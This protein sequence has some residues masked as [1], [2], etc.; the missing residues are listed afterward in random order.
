MI[1]GIRC[2]LSMDEHGFVNVD[3]YHDMQPG[4]TLF[5]V[6]NNLEHPI[7]Y[8]EWI[9]RGVV[10]Q[11]GAIDLAEWVIAAKREGCTIFHDSEGIVRAANLNHLLKNQN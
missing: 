8:V 1:D 7:P 3:I 5:G 9:V 10:D 4:E 2:E 11:Q 6:R